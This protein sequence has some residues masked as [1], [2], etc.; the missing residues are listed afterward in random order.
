M[1]ILILIQCNHSIRGYLPQYQKRLDGPY[2]S[3]HHGFLNN[4]NIYGLVRGFLLEEPLFL[5]LLG[6]L[7]S[8]LVVVGLVYLSLLI[9]LQLQVVQ[10]EEALKWR[11]FS[12]NREQ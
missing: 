8:I 2:N 1:G 11:L 7:L 4:N 5:V 9:A 12:Y 3:T 6:L 10:V